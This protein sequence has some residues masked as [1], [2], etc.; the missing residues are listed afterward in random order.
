[1]AVFL[2]K[3]AVFVSFRRPLLESSI[4]N[5]AG[6]KPRA[7]SYLELELPQRKNSL[8]I[9]P[10]AV[11]S[12]ITEL[13]LNFENRYIRSKLSFVRNIYGGI[14]SVELDGYEL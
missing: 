13:A 5:M 9:I 3:R 11:L 6:L 7:G 2:L 8:D 4:S 10:N 14:I 12:P 1:M